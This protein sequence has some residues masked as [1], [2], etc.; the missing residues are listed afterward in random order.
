MTG[1]H[2]E[3]DRDARLTGRGRAVDQEFRNEVNALHGRLNDLKERVVKLEA[4]VPHT[5]ESLARIEKSVEK[6]NGHIVKA[7]W[8]IVA[9]FI[10]VVFQFTV[11]GGFRGL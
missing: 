10:G 5:N 8:M 9:L 2:R 11:N 1:N 3:I 4:Q 7:I 6:I